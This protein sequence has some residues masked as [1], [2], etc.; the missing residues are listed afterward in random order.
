MRGLDLWPAP[1][2]GDASGYLPQADVIADPRPRRRCPDGWDL[3]HPDI[4]QATESLER[5]GRLGYD[6]GHSTSFSICDSYPIGGSR[7]GRSSQPSTTY[8]S[9]NE[10]WPTTKPSKQELPVQ[11][12]QHG[13]NGRSFSSLSNYRRHIR[14]RSKPPA[15]CQ[16]CGQRFS[17]KGARDAHQAQQRCKVVYF[18]SNGVPF[19]VPA[20]FRRAM[21]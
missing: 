2:H 12:W 21:P 7:E 15:M 9:N 3:F 17:R 14:E 11:C 13:C 18:D 19:K 8:D 5:D 1:I 6:L 10:Q 16:L 4:W 20:G